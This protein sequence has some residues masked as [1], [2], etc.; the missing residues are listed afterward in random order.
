MAYANILGFF[1]HEWIT[2]AHADRI[3]DNFPEGMYDVCVEFKNGTE[4]PLK[5]CTRKER[6]VECIKIYYKDGTPKVDPEPYRCWIVGETSS[7]DICDSLFLGARGYFRCKHKNEYFPQTRNEDPE[8]ISRVRVKVREKL[9]KFLQ[10][11]E[12]LDRNLFDKS[13]ERDVEIYLN[14][15]SGN[16]IRRVLGL[17]ELV[18]S[19]GIG[20]TLNFE[21][22][23]ASMDQLERLANHIELAETQDFDFIPELEEN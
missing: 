1:G 18:D 19:D 4:T 10:I 15:Y 6:N 12:K 11:P 21:I 13:P 23:R 20:I 5:C 22:E 8:D 9:V 2:K 17:L 14:N 16:W 3:L 7:Y